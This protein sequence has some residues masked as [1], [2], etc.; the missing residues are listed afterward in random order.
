LPAASGPGRGAAAGRDSWSEATDLGRAIRR[1]RGERTQ[2]ALCEQAGLNR[3][4]WSLYET[5]QRRPRE[6]NLARIVAALGCSRLELEEAVWQL[7]RQR[8]GEAQAGEEEAGA[9]GLLAEVI[10]F[11]QT[12]S[13][14]EQETSDPVRRD[15]A[16]PS[17]PSPSGG[18]ERAPGDPLR[19]ELRPI[20]QRFAAV[21]EDLLMFLVRARRGGV[22][23]ERV[24]DRSEHV[25]SPTDEE[26]RVA[27]AG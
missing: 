17:L 7:R 13:A 16:P 27:R 22:S 8:L 25:G 18:P 21:L 2:A 12:S 23:A 14:R 15:E 9:A 26:P 6:G 10:R 11:T 20:V 1:L 4:A 19:Q 3:A 5:G 24:T